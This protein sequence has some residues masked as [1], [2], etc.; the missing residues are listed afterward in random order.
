LETVEEVVSS[1]LPVD[2]NWISLGATEAGVVG[3]TTF[4]LDSNDVGVTSVLT[5]GFSSI[6]I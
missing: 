2:E 3:F 6:S 1:L 5:V 4:E